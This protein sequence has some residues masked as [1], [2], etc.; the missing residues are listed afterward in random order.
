MQS[1]NL[2]TNSAA[3]NTYYNELGNLSQ[4]MLLHEGAVSPAFAALLRACG[5]QVGWTLAEQYSLRVSRTD[6]SGRKPR[7]RLDGALLDDYKLVQVVAGLAEEPF[8]VE[9]A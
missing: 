7:I 8:L 1:L 2:K 3:V 9:S 4:L 5:S 6:E